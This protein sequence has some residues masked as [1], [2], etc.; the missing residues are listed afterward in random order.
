[1]CARYALFRYQD[2]LPGLI[3]GTG[4]E[5]VGSGMTTGPDEYNVAPTT[6]VPVVVH[7]GR[8]LTVRWMHW[9]IV[10]SWARDF[11]SHRPKPVNARVETVAEKPTFRGCVKRQ[12]CLVPM[13][14]FYEWTDEVR[15]GKP[16]KQ[17][18]FISRKDGRLL[19]TAGIYDVWHREQEDERESVAIL[20]TEPNAFMAVH[21]DRMP[22]FIEQPDFVPYCHPTQLPWPEARVLCIPMPGDE[23]TSWPVTTEMSNVRYRGSDAIIPV[24]ALPTQ[25]E[26]F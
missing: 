10:P 19:F 11:Q 2:I 6:D 3:W 21:H 12:R 17:P 8:K 15:D 23:L 18:H 24:V 26:L 7:N 22:C 13:S 5:R 20:T 4:S 16:Y 9:G 14:G 1:M 25:S